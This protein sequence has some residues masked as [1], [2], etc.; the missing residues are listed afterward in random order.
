MNFYRIAMVAACPFPAAF[1]SSGLIREMSLA[2]A[3]RGHEV[4]IIAYHLG[5]RDFNTDGLIIHRTPYIPF[6][7]KQCSGISPGK[8]FLDFLLMMKLAQVIKTKGIELIHTHNYEAPPAGYFSRLLY[9]T[10]VIY[11]AHNTMYHE[12]PTYFS[13]TGV[14]RIARKFGRFLDHV[15]P[16]RADHTIA[17]SHQQNAY[18]LNTGVDSRRISIIPPGIYPESF[19]GGDGKRIRKLLNLG[20][21]PLIIYTGGLQPYQNSFILIDLLRHCLKNR[22][23]LHLLIVAR[24][25]PEMMKLRAREAGVGDRIHFLQ[26]NGLEWERDS[27]AAADIGIVPR[28]HCI[29]FPIKLLNYLAAGKPVVCFNGLIP[30]SPLSE[31]VHTVEDGNIQ[32]MADTVTDILNSPEHAHDKVRHGQAL[33]AENHHWDRNIQQVESIY[34]RVMGRGSEQWASEPVSQ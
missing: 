31:A 17:L 28:L 6:Y 19:Q 9:K 25:A 10:P 15:I 11:H 27:L 30:Q 14:K 21:A 20:D 5:S 33:I 18:L 16:A 24:S 29:G 34:H 3:A 1:A 7:R 32:A 13:H 22:P 2:L 23:D 8:P 12:L 4:H 26:G